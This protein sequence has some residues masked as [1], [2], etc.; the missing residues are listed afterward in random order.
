[1]ELIKY[2]STH[3]LT[4]QELIDLA[5]ISED[6]L[7]RFQEEKRMP[8]SSYKIS[9]KLTCD[10]FFGEHN[11]QDSLE[12]YAKGSLAWIGILQST[13]NAEEAFEIFSNRYKQTVKTLKQQGYQPS[14]TKLNEGL[15]QHIKEEWQHFLDGI[16]GL[17]TKSGLP[18]DIA[19]KE[20]A[21][22]QINEILEQDENK[23]DIE[24]L[25][26][27]IDLLDN[28]SSLFAPHERLRSSRHRLVDEVRRQHKLEA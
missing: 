4:R 27:A 9:L 17:C 11:E 25:T 13:D 5:K 18:E 22:S 6:E 20:I 24:T 28:A 15:E 16:Y 7:Q 23:R 19:A 10:S 26:K 8:K 21:I 2:L 3:F 14:D 1:M 12:Y